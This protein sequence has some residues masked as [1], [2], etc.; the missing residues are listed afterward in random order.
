MRYSK[1]KDIDR[2]CRAYLRNRYRAQ[3][4]LPAPQAYPCIGGP[5]DGETIRLSWIGVDHISTA[6]LK[7]RGK[8]GQYR[9]VDEKAYWVSAENLEKQ[10]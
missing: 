7:I 3:R 1:N 2:R 9:V 10:S 5:L 4:R 8:R 6:V